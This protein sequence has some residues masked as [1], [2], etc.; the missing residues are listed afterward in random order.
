M[1]GKHPVHPIYW[2][3]ILCAIQAYDVKLEYVV[4]PVRQQFSVV[5]SPVGPVGQANPWRTIVSPTGVR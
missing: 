4:N 1:T 3:I 5:L 2:I